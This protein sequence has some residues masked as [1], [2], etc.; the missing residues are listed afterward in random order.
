MVLGW[1]SAISL[2]LAAALPGYKGIHAMA[3]PQFEKL[4]LRSKAIDR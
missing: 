3:V 4:F 1:A 2:M